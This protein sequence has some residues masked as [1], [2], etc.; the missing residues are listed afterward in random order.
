MAKE[1]KGIIRSRLIVLITI[2]LVP[3]VIFSIYN[4]AD[5]NLWYSSDPVIKLVIIKIMCPLVFSI[6]W[7]FFLILFVNR[8]ATTLDDFDK[9]ISV[10]PSRLKFFY[11]INAIYILLIFIF[12]IITPIIS[13]LSFASFA[14]RLTTFKKADWDDDTETSFITKSMMILFSIIP[15]FCA[16][17]VLPDFI[18]LAIFLWEVIWI[19]LLPYLF[20]ISYSLFTS[21]SIGALIILFYTSGISEYEQMSLEPA[22]KQILWNVKIIEIFL[23]GFFF[24]FR[25]CKFPGH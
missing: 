16:I 12:P 4:L 19:P 11:G 22:K 14:W 1:I 8:I 15:V 23:F 20:I 17:S 9:T 2:I 13:I 10:V 7:L 5:F 6:S 24:F 21:L 25:Y 3:I 18:R